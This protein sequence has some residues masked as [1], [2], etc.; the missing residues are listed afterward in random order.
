MDKKID[1]K[2]F[3]ASFLMV[4]ANLTLIGKLNSDLILANLKHKV[5]QPSYFRVT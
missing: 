2:K 5:N 1:T 3:R 4:T